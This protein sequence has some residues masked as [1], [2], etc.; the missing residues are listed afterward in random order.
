MFV[1]RTLVCKNSKS[2]TNDA[3]DGRSTKK[4]SDM[5]PNGFVI[6]Y[7]RIYRVIYFPTT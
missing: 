6:C 2:D 3:K 7:K 5:P 1:S 4:P